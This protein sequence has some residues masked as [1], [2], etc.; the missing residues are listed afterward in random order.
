MCREIVAWSLRTRGCQNLFD[1]L[2]A[3]KPLFPRYLTHEHA[4][5]V[6]LPTQPFE[7]QLHGIEYSVFG[8]ADHGNAGHSASS[9]LRQAC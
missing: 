5:A 6:N 1:P 4:V 7:V 2:T 3:S 8:L 9:I